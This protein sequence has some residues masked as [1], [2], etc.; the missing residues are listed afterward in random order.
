MMYGGGG[1]I[2]DSIGDIGSRVGSSKEYRE[3][4]DLVLNLLSNLYSELD[5]ILV[6]ASSTFLVHFTLSMLWLKDLWV[7][8]WKKPYIRLT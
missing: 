5:S 1:N 8:Q 4:V 3:K 7:G 2:G 6:G